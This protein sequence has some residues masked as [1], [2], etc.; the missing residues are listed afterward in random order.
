MR[1]YI[2]VSALIFVF[3]VCLPL[4]AQW[5][6][7]YGGTEDD[8]ANSVQQTSDGGY[9]VAGGTESYGLGNSDVWVLKLS[10][11]GDIEWQRTFGGNENEEAYA[12]Q[13]TSDSGFIVVGYTESFGEGLSDSLILK[14]SADGDIEWQYTCGRSGDDWWNSVQQTSDGGYIVGG[15]SD[16]F[17]YGGEFVFWVVKL[18]SVGDIDWQYSYSTGVNCY[19]RSIQETSDEGYIVAGHMEPSII[20]GYDLLILKLYPTGLIEEQR[21]YGGV[22]DDWANFVQQTEDG[23]YFVAGYTG[24]F[25]AGG[26]DVWVLKLDSFLDIEWERTYGGSQDDW[27]TSAQQTSDGGFIVAGYTESFGAE[28]SDFWVLKISSLGV[29]EW[30]TTYGKG[31]EAAF[32]VS[33]TDDTTGFVVAGTTGSYTAGGLD[34]LVLKL[35]SDGTIDPS[36]VLPGS[37]NA[38]V[39]S[40]D[41]ALST[42]LIAPFSTGV[43]AEISVVPSQESDSDA[44]LIC[45]DLMEISGY[46]RTEG[47]TGL[48]GVTITFSG[49]EGT[50]TTDV[51]GYYLHEVSFGWSGTATP[52]LDG[53]EFSPESREYTEVTS[54]QTDQDYTGYFLYVISGVVTD[55]GGG[56][57]DEVTIA[58]SNSGGEATT[59]ADGSYTHTVK[60]GWTGDA[61]PSK[62]CYTTFVPSFR[63]YDPVYSDQTGQD[64][65]G[66]FVAPV[67]S[68]TVLMVSSAAPVSGVVMSGLP[69]NPTT[70]ASGSY[71]AT[72]DCLWSGTATPTKDRTV[73]SPRAQSY[74]DVSTSQTDDY[75]AYTGWY[76]SGVVQTNGGAPLS[77]VTM[78]FRDD[79]DTTFILTG[80]DGSYS[81]LVR[82]G[83]TVTVTPEKVGY[84][85]SP[86]SRTHTNVTS[87]IS[88]QDYTGT[89]IQHILIISAEE[90]G[91]TQPVPGTYSYDY[92]TEVQV[93]ALADDKYEFTEWSGDVFEGHIHNNPVTITM[94]SDKSI[95]AQFDKTSLCFIA[96]A[97]YGKT[98]HPHVEIL[99]DFRDQ[100]LM[101]H[102][103]GRKIV[104]LYYRFSPAV[105]GFISQHLV[106]RLA[107]RIHLVPV[108]ALSFTALRLGPGASA[109]LIALVFMLAV[110]L[111]KRARL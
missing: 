110:C 41:A 9:I 68:G 71:A 23:G 58:F 12:V 18:T 77:G 70:D 24:S 31:D 79:I 55:G 17:G 91:T 82:D 111:S 6:V 52:S 54:D 8:W 61:T 2:F 42:T 48:E 40:T 1:K 105:A 86:S 28:F 4:K 25:G 15:G 11:A 94:D 21:Y 103:A 53:Y 81:H 90:G 80:T 45:E 99:R 63:H 3:T 30:E 32:S 10:L 60:E 106:L 50:A 98:S 46:V 107:A 69:G 34:L 92:G 83:R 57:I 27:G 13:E 75:T 95:T 7:H 109:A 38:V 14:L 22:Q 97:A 36:C 20:G 72:V 39:K 66:T 16:A 56:G 44:Y 89:I 19:L 100:Y 37:S 47:G 78:T 84:I 104:D 33:E 29:I 108:V 65:T 96:S 101:S 87:D 35:Y 64:Y 88:G 67:I 59:A 26:W 102:A 76:I 73:F 51:N 49:G 93:T 62:P 43:T 74:T 85:F 5:A